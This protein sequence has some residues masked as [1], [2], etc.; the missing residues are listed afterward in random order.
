MIFILIFFQISKNLNSYNAVQIQIL[1]NFK[2]RKSEARLL[3]AYFNKHILMN[4]NRS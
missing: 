4:S 2:Y 3:D 1:K